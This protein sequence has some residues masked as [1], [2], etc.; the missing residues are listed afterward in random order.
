M[1]PILKRMKI[2]AVVILYNP[3]EE[4]INNIRSYLHYVDKV[5]VFDNSESQREELINKISSLSNI[6]YSFDGE[7]KG[8]AVRLNQASA[9]AIAYGADWLLT[10]D[11]D[12]YFNKP[13]ILNYIQCLSIYKNKDN[14]SMFGVEYIE[15][16]HGAP[17]CLAVEVEQLITSGSI[18]NLS[19]FERMGGFDEALFIDEVDLEYCYNSITKGFKIIQFKNIFLNHNLG[20]ISYHRSFKNLQLTP[21]TL[22]S[23]IRV[24]YMIRNFLYVN[25][26][27]KNNFKLDKKRR[28]KALFNRIKNNLL[29]GKKGGLLIKY[30][31]KALIDYKRKKMGKF[32]F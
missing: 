14:V 31:L 32:T 25:D 6:T 29:Y 19:A 17:E 12:S 28:N 1:K 16:T 5:Y 30:I 15:N 10:M 18:L 27:Y 22:H 24:Y 21:R 23:P 8:I 3:G 13:D 9:I 26:K 4:V 11:Q 7:N 2:A 20:E